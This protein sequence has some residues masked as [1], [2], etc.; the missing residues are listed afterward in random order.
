M[1]S[2]IVLYT[3]LQASVKFADGDIGD[4]TVDPDIDRIGS[5]IVATAMFVGSIAVIVIIVALFIM[6]MLN[7]NKAKWS[8]VALGLVAVFV[9]SDPQGAL[10]LLGNIGNSLNG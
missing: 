9:A 7:N 6:K 10:D 3:A 8:A 2:D 1:N 4:G 5:N